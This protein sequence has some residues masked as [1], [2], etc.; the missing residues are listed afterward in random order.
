MG[1]VDYDS[2]S[3]DEAVPEKDSLFAAL[4]RPKN[5]QAERKKV[6]LVDLPREQTHDE[7]SEGQNTPSIPSGLSA[8]LPAPK[9]SEKRSV[10]GNNLT[11][12]SHNNNSAIGSHQNIP[13]A[14]VSKS[15]LAFR[16]KTIRTQKSVNP[17]TPLFSIMAKKEDKQFV[18]QAPY[19]PLLA[20]ASRPLLQPSP[21]SP[22]S[23]PTE[24]ASD[25]YR[26]DPETEYAIL[27]MEKES[28]KRRRRDQGIDGPMQEY[29]VA[30]QYELNAANAGLEDAAPVRFVGAGKH[31]LS[32]LLSLAHSQK[33]A[34]EESFADQK[35]AMRE[36]KN[37]YGR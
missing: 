12:A 28:R 20:T 18:E 9:R 1:L 32:S 26:Y 2:D 3:S 4:P 27:P 16:P 6:I 35:R 15:N 22:V 23:L 14:V 34:L 5:R 11:S 19:V 7:P 36:G 8:L 29:N 25:A 21:P 37:K 13:T 10:G 30:E 31:Q 24:H 33:D 17:K